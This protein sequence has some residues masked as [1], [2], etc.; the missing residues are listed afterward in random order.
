[1]WTRLMK[2]GSKGGMVRPCSVLQVPEQGRE[3]VLSPR[4]F[5]LILPE[6]AAIRLGLR[7]ASLGFLAFLG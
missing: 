3:R 6:A 7:H 2:G 4:Q 5:W 1:M